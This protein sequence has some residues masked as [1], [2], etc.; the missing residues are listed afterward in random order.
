MT[1]ELHCSALKADGKTNEVLENHSG[2]LSRSF[3]L[4]SIVLTAN[5]FPSKDEKPGSAGGEGHSIL[6][7]RSRV[8]SASAFSKIK[9]SKLLG[10]FSLQI[11]KPESSVGGAEMLALVATVAMHAVRVDHQLKLLA[12]RL[13]GIYQL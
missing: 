10:T 1:E 11:L 13:K 6:E 9:L 7:S 2:T 8:V 4:D 3:L 12:S 5:S